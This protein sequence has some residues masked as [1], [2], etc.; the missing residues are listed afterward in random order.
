MTQPGARQIAILG[1]R[2]AAAAAG[3]GLLNNLI[4]YWP[5][6]EVSGNLLDAH[7]N[8]LDLTD[9]ATVT[10]NT[11]K[12]YATARQYTA[13]NAEYHSR[14]SEAL[15]QTGDVE[16]TLAAWCYADSFNLYPMI[17]SKSNI[18]Y[19][20]YYW[21]AAGPGFEFEVGNGVASVGSIKATSFGVASTSTW[22]FVVTWHDPVANTMSIQINNGTVDS[23]PT[24]GPAGTGAS[25]VNIARTPGAGGN[26]WNGRIGPTMLWKSA[27]GSGGVLT[28][29][30]KT[31]L[32]NGGAGLPYAS[33]TT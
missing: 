31:A 8:G 20:L 22:Y 9:N 2:K 14:A 21:T 13:A 19:R 17:F 29:E 7:S 27:A 1:G 25:A 12:V 28:A 26:I 18:E 32:Y 6:D 4:A 33:F 3:N 16:F 5:G 15:L 23:G 10:N 24:S 11:G 30:Q